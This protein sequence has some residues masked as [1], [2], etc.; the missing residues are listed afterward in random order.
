MKNSLICFWPELFLQKGAFT[1]SSHQAELWN[2]YLQDFSQKT[3]E[4]QQQQEQPK[5]S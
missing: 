3:N 5:N 4:Q 2:K 1:L